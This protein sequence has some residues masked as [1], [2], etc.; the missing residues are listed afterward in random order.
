MKAEREGGEEEGKNGSR[1]SEAIYIP[2]IP[3]ILWM[4]ASIGELSAKPHF[5]MP[6]R[7]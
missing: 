3:L 1:N 2:E 5:Q 4:G 7:K 6:S